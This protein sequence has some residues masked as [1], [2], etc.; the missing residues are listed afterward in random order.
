M[1]LP[2]VNNS[3]IMILPFVNNSR[4]MKLPCNQFYNYEIAV[5]KILEL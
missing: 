2:Y 5:C 4:I 3:R 1:I